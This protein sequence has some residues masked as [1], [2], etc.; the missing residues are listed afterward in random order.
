MK[1]DFSNQR[2]PGVVLGARWTIRSFGLR[3]LLFLEYAFFTT[4]SNPA[5]SYE[6]LSLGGDQ[7]GSGELPDKSDKEGNTG[8]VSNSVERGLKG[9]T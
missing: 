6:Y 1:P 2:V 9:I 4:L 5:G 3:P 7:I 8:R